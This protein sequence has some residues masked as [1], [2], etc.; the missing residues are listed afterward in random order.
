MGKRRQ[1]YAKYCVK[2]FDH[3]TE[4]EK[5]TDHSQTRSVGTSSS[6]ELCL[7]AQSQASF[8]DISSLNPNPPEF[9]SGDLVNQ[10]ATP[11]KELKRTLRMF[12]ST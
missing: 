7:L 4:E 12:A 8:V 11:L 10:S 1:R 3:A 9:T 6:V 5:K 2:I